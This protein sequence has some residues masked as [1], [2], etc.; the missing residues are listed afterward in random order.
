MDKTETICKKE[1]MAELACSRVHW[2]ALLL[3]RRDGCV[4]ECAC[5][6][7]V[8]Y[9]FNTERLTYTIHIYFYVL[10]LRRIFVTAACV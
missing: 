6:R 2:R 4:D 5:I 7:A 10:Y 3:Y 9:V 1:K 8:E